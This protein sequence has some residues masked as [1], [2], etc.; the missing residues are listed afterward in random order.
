M[1][2]TRDVITD[3]LPAYLS[4]EASADT[5]ALVEELAG[6]DP[7]IGRLVEAARN[8]RSDAMAQ[9][10]VSLPPNL[11]REVV[12]RT[13]AV[14]RRRAWTLGLA[15]FF[16]FIPFSFVFADRIR[17]VMFRD[18]PGSRLFWIG[19]ACLWFD[20]LRQSRRLRVRH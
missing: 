14:L 13:R 3:L 20:Y 10:T 11:E 12:A 7:D 19:A 9:S 2:I 4:G 1:N 5:R 15:L 8:E 18:A 17:F 6:R 16:T